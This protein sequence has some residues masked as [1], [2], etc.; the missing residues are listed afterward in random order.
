MTWAEVKANIV[1]KQVTAPVTSDPWERN[2]THAD[3]M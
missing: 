1:M 2:T 3:G